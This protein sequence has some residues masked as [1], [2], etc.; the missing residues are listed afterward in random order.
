MA[1]TVESLSAVEFR[2]EL[3]RL[4]QFRTR[5]ASAGPL[6]AAVKKIED[7]PAYAQSRLLARILTALTYDQGVFRRAEV[8]ALD[9]ETL[10]IVRSL[11][12]ARAAATSPHEEWVRAVDAASAAQGRCDG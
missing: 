11:V 4:A 8:T 3:Q 5:P 9:A 6:A 7:N 2:E 10:A 1:H 12:E